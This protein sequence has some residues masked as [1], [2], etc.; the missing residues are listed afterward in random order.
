LSGGVKISA[1]LKPSQAILSRKA[2]ACAKARCH[3]DRPE[4]DKEAAWAKHKRRA[5]A[6]GSKVHIGAGKDTAII[7]AA[8][9]TPAN[10][11]DVAMA[12]EI[13]PDEPGEVY[14]DRAYDALSVEVA[15]EAK[16]GTSKLMRKGHRWLKPATREA[17][18]RP[19]RR[20]RSRVEN[21]FGTWKRV[22]RMKRMRW[23]GLAKARLQV[24]LAA[25]AYNVKR[26]RR[27]KCA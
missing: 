15:I 20:V 26:F 13:I 11:A 21:I 24:H 10:E 23:M 3:R 18:N 25:I 7:R 12:P 14:G 16:G 6:H 5:P 19:L 9:T 8:A 1:C 4:S 2:L 27:L 22:Y 17:R